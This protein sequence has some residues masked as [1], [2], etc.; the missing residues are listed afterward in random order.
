MYVASYMLF[1]LSDLAW[2]KV[3]YNRI[4]ECLP[5]NYE[6]TL[7]ILQDNFTDESIVAVLSCDDIREANRM[8]LDCLVNSVKSKKDVLNLCDQLEKIHGATNLLDILIQLRQST[9]VVLI[10][11]DY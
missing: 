11:I 7:E 5:D 4:L 3:H 9:A 6:A 8:M 10:C 1:I 2:I